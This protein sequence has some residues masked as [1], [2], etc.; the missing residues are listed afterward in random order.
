MKLIP[1]ITKPL[2]IALSLITL[3]PSSLCGQ[4]L[5]VNDTIIGR[6]LLFGKT[7][8]FESNDTT[9]IF[10]TTNTGI[11]S[12]LYANQDFENVKVIKLDKYGAIVGTTM[13][14]EDG[15]TRLVQVI[16]TNDSSFILL[17]RK[18]EGIVCTASSI[19]FKIDHDCN[20]VWRNEF[21]IIPNSIEHSKEVNSYFL[22]GANC[23]ARTL[24]GWL[25]TSELIDIDDSGEVAKWNIFDRTIN[26]DLYFIVS[27][28]DS[29]DQ[30]FVI[31]T[32]KPDSLHLTCDVGYV[33][34]RNNYFHPDKRFY[35]TLKSINSSGDLLKP[36]RCFNFIGTIRHLVYDSIFNSFICLGNLTSINEDLADIR[37]PRLVHHEM[38]SNHGIFS[39]IDENGKVVSEKISKEEGAL[40]FHDLVML[41]DSKYIFAFR[42]LSTRDVHIKGIQLS[43][44]G[45][46]EFNEYRVPNM[47]DKRVYNIA[48]KIGEDDHLYVFI[49]QLDSGE[50]NFLNDIAI[51]RVS[52]SRLFNN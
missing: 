32:R 52:I 2:L 39:I 38:V 31:D 13:F 27:N 42:N 20:I 11:T 6:N 28:P 49:L 7:F 8:V 18:S 36:E 3:S 41:E 35:Y 33:V 19:V 25:K 17:L 5:I 47:E 43:V 48:L 21:D 37:F 15:S 51:H 16:M 45:F 14:H 30:Y 29:L 10:G 12:T 23:I 40:R 24:E 4:E 26:I 9:W 50:Q 22:F 1:F 34:T 44:N 46:V